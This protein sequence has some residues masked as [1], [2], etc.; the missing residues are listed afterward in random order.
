M[1][2]ATFT[3]KYFKREYLIASTLCVLGFI[4]YLLILTRRPLIYGIDGP[5]YLI[6]V[7]SILETGSLV[8]GDPPLSFYLFTFLTILLGGDITLGVRVGVALFTALSALP[9]YFLVKKITRLELAGYTAVLVNF[10]SSPHIRLVN[11]LLKN[12]VGACFLIF[13][14]YYLHL[15]IF[16]G[17]RIRNLVFSLVFLVLTGLTHILDFG[18]AILFLVLYLVGAVLLDIKRRVVVKYLGMLIL[19]L[20]AFAALTLTFFPS[21]F[22]D[23]FKG[24][25]FLQD[26]FSATGEVNPFLF[27]FDLRGGGFI[28]PVLAIG[29]ILLFIEWK[30][31]QKEKILFLAVVTVVGLLLSLPFIPQQWL[32]RFLLMEFI[33]MSFILGFCISKL[34]HKVT[35]AIFFIIIILPLV[36]QGFE[37]SKRLGPT[38]NQ[39]GCSELETINNL[40]PSNSVIIVEPRLMYWIEYMVNSDI[41]KHP[42]P[43][44]RQSYTNIFIIFQ[45]PPNRPMPPHGTVVF[46]GEFLLLMEL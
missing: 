41:A 10:I 40:I 18:V 34:Q 9:T 15:L 45:L 46:E 22:N 30:N 4:F 31:K 33:P 43:D 19:V 44:L 7:E 8:Y 6:Q 14:I 32:W 3:E 39:K 25:V 20:G 24:L 36:I 5:Y 37:A 28:I 38:I 21:L 11:D 1:T 16:N 35:I 42:S 29:V 12:A 13:F 17:Q 2:S 27:I 23:F 26:L